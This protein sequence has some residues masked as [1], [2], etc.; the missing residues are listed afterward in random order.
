MRAETE[1]PSNRQEQS[2]EVFTVVHN[3]FASPRE[4][5]QGLI[6]IMRTRIAGRLLDDKGD[7]P[8]DAFGA[9]AGTLEIN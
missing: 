1:K 3:I 6:R 9:L 5:R 4:Q 7:S 2:G 8:R